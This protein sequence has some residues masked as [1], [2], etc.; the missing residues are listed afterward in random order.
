MTDVENAL[1]V[2]ERGALR[3]SLASTVDP[4]ISSIPKVELHI[5]VEGIISADL[6]WKFSQR[7]N[8]TIINP[9]TGHPFSSLAELQDSHDTLKSRKKNRMDNTEETLSFFEA[10]YGG[11]EVLKTQLDYYD[12]AMAYYERAAAMKVRYAEIFFDPQGHT[13]CGTR[14]ETMMEGFREAQRR[15]REELG[16]Q[17]AWIMCFL[18]DQSP[19]SA[20]EH[21]D[22]ALKYCDMIVGIGLDSNEVDRPPL[23]FDEIFVRA[24]KDGF[25][26]TA[27]CDVGKPYP[28]EH[29]HQVASSIAGT[30]SDRIDHGLNAAGDAKLMG[31]IKGKGLGMTICPWSY[32][33][34]QPMDEVFQRIRALFDAGIMI[35]IAS[36]DPAFMEDTWVLENLLVV[37]LYCGFTNLEIQR[38]AENAI[39]MCWNSEDAKR[40][41]LR[42][43]YSI[44]PGI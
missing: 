4:Y 43:L 26:V 38:L 12:L 11:F 42:E 18:R 32:I 24:R 27:H 8:Q 3:H 22:A 28:L 30:G 13:R 10:Y 7:N 14:W 40:Q 15:A 37:K 2:A 23:L 6:K 44:K 20:M 19:E 17:S 36:D 39:K 21:Y 33:R 31:L 41:M 16:V 25:R 35:A 9:R 1:P 29:I 34:H 5:H